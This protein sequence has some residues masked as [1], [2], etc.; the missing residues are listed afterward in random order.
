MDVFALRDKVVAD[1][2]GYIESFVRIRDERLAAFV[3]EVFERGDLWPEAILQLNPAYQP[4]PTLDELAT[5]GALLP[6]TA[7]FFRHQ[8]GH[9]IRLYHHQREAIEI[10]R[11]WEPYVVT[12]GTGSGKSLTY[13]IPIFD[14]I[15]RNQPERR[16][17]R[18]I[19]V[20]PMNALINSQYTALETY[21]KQ[22]PGCPVRFEKY[23]GQQRD[24]ARQRILDDPPH[25]LLTNYVML[26]YMLVRPAERHFTDRTS[27]HLEFLVLDEL[28]TYRGRQGADVAMLIRRVRER[29]ANPRML[30]VGTSATVASE[31]DRAARKR[32]AAEVATKLFGVTVPPENVVDETLRRAIQVSAPST[33]EALRVAVES[34]LPAETPAALAHDGLA[35]WVEETFGVEL[36]DGHL[37]RRSEPITFAKGVRELSTGCGL[38]EPICSEKLRA[39]LALGNRLRT[40]AGEPLFAFRLHQFLAAGGTVYATLEPSAIRYRGLQGEYYAP[41]SD[42]EKLL[43]PLVFCRECGQ[44]YYLVD[45]NERD[46]GRITPRLPFLDDEN[47]EAQVTPGYIALQEDGLW[48]DSNSDELPDF[49]FEYRKGNPRLKATYQAHVAARLSVRPDG[50]VAERGAEGSVQAWFQPQPFL[51]CLRCGAAYDRT[52]R[53]DFRKLTRLS[54]TGR[55]TATTLV[56]SSAIVQLREDLQVPAEARKVLSFTDNRQDASLQAGH[57]N[58]FILVALVRAA[59]YGA[60]GERAVLDHANITQAVFQTLALD[61]KAYAKAPAAFGPGKRQNEEAMQRLLEYRL[62]EDLRRGWRVI[63]PNLEQ[64]GLLTIEYD[65]LREVCGE[66]AAW[67]QH[68]ILKQASPELRERVVGTFLDY[69]RREMAIDATVLEPEGHGELRRRVEQ[70]LKDPW[71]LDKDDR[72]RDSSIFV[73]GSGPESDRERSTASTSR[74]VRYLRRRDTWGLRQD[75]SPHEGTTLVE[76][77]VRALDGQYLTMVQ[78]ESGGRGFQLLVR[79]MQ[80]KLGDGTPPAPDP[81]RMKWK[82]NARMEEVERTA[83][84]FFAALYRETANQLK[85]IEGLAHTGQI[86][87]E[88]RQDREER[89]RKG[90]LA[91]LFCSPTMELGVDIR[92][93]NV[94]HLRNIP[95]TPANYAQRSGRAGRGGQPALVVAFCSEGS[96]HDQYFYRRPDRMVAGAVAPARLD[97]GNEELVRAHVH[98]VWLAATGTSLHRGMAEV[99]DLSQPGFTL[100]AE[101]Q[102]RATLSDTKLSEVTEEC[103]RILDAAGEDTRRAP[104]CTPQWLENTLR[105]A[106]TAFDS[107]FNRWRELYG[108]AVQQRDEARR[109]VDNP[110]TRG[111]DRREAEQREREA[112]NQIDL[113]LNRS[114]ESDESDFYPY[115]YLAS[116]GFVPGYSFPRLPVRALVPSGDKTHIIQRPRFLALGEFGP[117][118]VIYHEGRKYRMARCVLPPGG[119]EGRLVTAKLCKMCG[120][121][122]EGANAAADRCEHCGVQMDGAHSQY[123]PTLFEMTAVRGNRVERITCDEEERVREGFFIETFYRFAPGSDGRVLQE[124]AVTKAPDGREILA[125]THATQ[126]TLWRVN[127]RW[128]RSTQNGF[129]LDRKSGYWA[130]RPGDDDRAPD[131]ETNDILSGVRPFVWDTRNLLLVKPT[132]QDVKNARSGED[133]L[134]SLGYAL[135]RAMQILFQVEEQEVAVE[136]IGEGPEERLLFWEAAEGGTGIWPRLFEDPRTLARVAVEALRLCHFDPG[137]GEDRAQGGCSRACYDCLLSYRNQPDHPLLDRHL[138]RDHLLLLSQ[139]STSRQTAGRSYD[140]Q[141]AWLDERCDHISGLEGDFLAL[142]HRTRRR[143]PDRV[144][145]RPEPDVFA[146]A[147]FFY[148]RDGARGVCVFCDGPDHDE[149]SRQA[150]DSAERAKLEDLGYRIVVIRHDVSIEDQVRRHVDVFGPGAS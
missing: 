136:R 70:S 101:I 117:R 36:E 104:W 86:P 141:Y 49:W 108:S 60:L 145:Y 119:V 147:D 12:T 44:E 34:P 139:S 55:S 120:Y 18:A 123:V 71:A 9:P 88:L 102:H 21:A 115:R 105:G 110:A 142:L 3:D 103:R 17:V 126:A 143:L 144:Q 35:A 66:P 100:N 150:R 45:R 138:I 125:L 15:L 57:F 7:G 38:P 127:H 59:L 22:N 50:S 4:G 33:A 122:H 6:A 112:K 1:Y 65:G 40:D 11:R 64:C 16:Q 32:A 89:F 130:R 69:L 47:E 116:E 30:H 109:I 5:Q 85:G 80:W 81:V 95:P 78:T 99:L 24:E 26:E 134:A 137:T 48:D 53:N 82:R 113:L 8:D 27:A 129:T 56:T 28:H 87:A 62:Y 52:E 84:Q 42:G 83:N 128:R 90:D 23:T 20:Y 96:P 149:L 106:A 43:Y 148:D 75:L 124:R 39:L 77:L 68:P 92:D 2:R 29:A 31:G 79:S 107:G 10:A 97:L 37:I 61:Q 121:F 14:H 51:L 140:E 41:Q 131:L 98:S 146:E 13:L 19:I 94:V 135:Q 133:F 63:Q 73:L 114:E 58:D 93:L 46:Q 76:A 25:I 67:E 118:N 72:L 74:I 54:H 111:K 91:A 132:D